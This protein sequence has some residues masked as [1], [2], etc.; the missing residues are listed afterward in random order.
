MAPG[1]AQRDSDM[2][3]KGFAAIDTDVESAKNGN[4]AEK[5]TQ[6]IETVY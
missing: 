3:M 6:A 1:G 2:L 4:R 5:E